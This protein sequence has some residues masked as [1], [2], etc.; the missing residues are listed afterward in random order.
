LIVIPNRIDFAGVLLV[1]DWNTICIAG[2]QG[3][4]LGSPR[5]DDCVALPDV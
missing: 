2:M 4:H 5:A 1:G 3:Q